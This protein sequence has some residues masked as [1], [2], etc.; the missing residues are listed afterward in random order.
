MS[1]NVWLT[2]LE[3]VFH[4]IQFY[5]MEV[6]A[7]N[8]VSRVPTSCIKKKKITEGICVHLCEQKGVPWKR[9]RHQRG[10]YINQGSREAKDG[11]RCRVL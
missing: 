10:G 7:L 9:E 1:T 6:N 4:Y 3:C 11:R 5:D 8:N 2:F